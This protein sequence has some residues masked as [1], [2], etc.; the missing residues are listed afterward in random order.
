MDV[1]LNGGDRG[2]SSS[3]GGGA[4]AGEIFALPQLPTV[5]ITDGHYYVI[6][7]NNNEVEPRRKDFAL[8]L[9]WQ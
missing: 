4:N 8:E 7:E 3:S 9:E 6:C 1:V 2:G 5:K